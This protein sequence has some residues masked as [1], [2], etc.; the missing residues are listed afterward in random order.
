MRTPSPGV[1]L[2]GT[3]ACDV[4]EG[5]GRVMACAVA[6]AVGST[7][8]RST[9]AGALARRHPQPSPNVYRLMRRKAREDGRARIA[10]FRARETKGRA[11]ASRR[12]A[13]R[14]PKR[15]EGLLRKALPRCSP[16]TMRSGE[17]RLAGTASSRAR[18]E[19]DFRGE[20]LAGKGQLSA[21]TTKSHRRPGEDRQ[22]AAFRCGRRPADSGRH[23]NGTWSV[24]SQPLRMA[25]PCAMLSAADIMRRWIARPPDWKR[26]SNLMAASSN[27][28]RASGSRWKRSESNR[29]I[30][31]P[32]A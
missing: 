10:N 29:R 6:W 4:A 14:L 25:G 28:S 8:I 1:A 27:R 17:S 5:I 30:V 31:F 12:A 13:G 2:D 15:V 22:G 16:V 23:G 7:G 11:C 18:R 9:V 24:G 21:K 20:G 19:A 26:C 3:A 32:T